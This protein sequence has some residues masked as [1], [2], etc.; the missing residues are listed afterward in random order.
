M[1]GMRMGMKLAIA[2]AILAFTV[3]HVHLKIIVIDAID[4]L[5]DHI[6]RDDIQHHIENHVYLAN[7][8]SPVSEENYIPLATTIVEGNL[9]RDLDGLFSR[10]GPNPIVIQVPESEH[11]K[12]HNENKNKPKPEPGKFKYY[13]WFDGHGHL[14]NLRIK[15]GRAFYTNAFI[16]T[17]RYT[18]EKNIYNGHQYFSNIGELKGISGLIK[19][20]FIGPNK[21]SKHGL[22][23]LTVGQA[24]THSIMTAHYKFYA[25]H[26]GS[27]PFELELN[28][29]GSI[30][31]GIGYESFGNVLD[32]PV[33]AHP[34]TDVRGGGKLIFHSYSL[35]PGL[36]KEFGSMKVGVY[37]P[38]VDEVEFYRGIRVRSS[39]SQTLSS[40]DNNNNNNNNNDDD[41]G[42]D[43]D[44]HTSFAHDL[45]FTENWIVIYDSSA[46]LDPM[47][48]MNKTGD[49]ITWNPDHRFKIGLIPRQHANGH[50]NNG[51]NGNNATT[52]SDVVWFELDQ[53]FMA[54]HPLNAWENEDGD[55][56]LWAPLSTSFDFS[57][58]RGS[59]EYHMAEIIMSTRT[60]PKTVK[61]T[62][63]DETYNVE[64]SRVQDDRIGQF[65]RF[66]IASILDPTLG[67]D[68]LSKG[69]AVFDMKEKKLHSSVLYR[70]G[71]IGGEAV[72][73]PKP[74]KSNINDNDH[75]HDVDENN[76]VYI[77][78]FVYNTI[79]EGSYFLLFDGVTNEQVTRVK[80]PRR[81]PFGF[82]ALWI[83]NH[84]LSQ[85]IE[86]H[87][88]KKKKNGNE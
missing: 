9:P 64:F 14:H 74:K 48:I 22:T 30:A 13:H 31:G 83:T 51:N 50:G 86:Y 72:I 54:V 63:I 85:H 75:D 20:I 4:D 57:L 11:L 39:S 62:F 88:M 1:M 45:M 66:G 55:V 41:D 61:M 35:D 42:D 80:L 25:C 47:Q 37:D 40:E 68:A 81:V 36:V 3:K 46:H 12:Q 29:D 43:G 78:T 87:K 73:I 28:D 49:F 17:P 2:V 7:N 53:P 24:N 19:A 33:S 52:S 67:G 69:F 71:D 10:N 23:A 79:D 77:G 84:Q 34:K 38:N 76:D 59:N 5:L 32:Y 27:L 18:I 60:A 8:Y 21:A 56:I 6:N 16:P 58:T 82:H 65:T 26:E 15:D 44:E 70:E